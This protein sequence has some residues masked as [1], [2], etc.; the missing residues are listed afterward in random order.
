MSQTLDVPF[1]FG[2]F[3]KMNLTLILLLLLPLFPLSYGGG[4][5]VIFWK[6]G[7]Q[8]G[9]N[10]YCH[11]CG[12]LQLHSGMNDEISCIEIQGNCR[13]K[14]WEHWN[15]QGE[16]KEFTSNHDDL[17]TIGWND[18]ISSILV[19]CYGDSYNQIEPGKVV[20]NWKGWEKVI[21][22]TEFRVT[23]SSEF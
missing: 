12:L 4:A 22:D 17:S 5:R 18:R 11:Q 3:G 13:V 23:V 10:F 20:Y 16:S 7:W 21:Y 8:K 6:H 15:Y 14:V 9:S 2:K 19:D 1:S